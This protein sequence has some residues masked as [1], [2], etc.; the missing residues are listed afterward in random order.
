[1]PVRHASKTIITRN[2]TAKS[3]RLQK[4]WNFSPGFNTKKTVWQAVCF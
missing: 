4:R 1:M 2:C 3:E